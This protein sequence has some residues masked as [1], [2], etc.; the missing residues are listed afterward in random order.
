[1]N[2]ALIKK[3]GYLFFAVIGSLVIS[4]LF[5]SCM[6]QTPPSPELVSP[7]IHIK[8]QPAGV[9]SIN[10]EVSGADMETI[11]K[12]IDV[13][14]DEII[15]EVPA[16]S[17]RTFTLTIENP[18]VTFTGEVT[19]DLTAGEEVD[20]V[21][22]LSLNEST[23][24]VPDADYYS[25]AYPGGRLVQIDDMNGSGWIERDY[26][27]LNLGYSLQEDFVPYDVDFDSRGRIYVANYSSTNGGIIRLGHINDTN[28]TQILSSNQ[29]VALAVDRNNDWIYFIE[30]GALQRCDVN[31]ANRKT[32][33]DASAQN[34]QGLCV[35]NEGMLYMVSNPDG[36]LIQQIDPSG[37]GVPSDT[38][39][40]GDLDYSWDVL[41][42]DN[43]IYVAD[44]SFGSAKI[45]RFTKD[46]TYVDELGYDP[47]N[48]SDQFEGPH[49]FLAVLNRGFIVIDEYEQSSDADDRL[50][51]FSGIS[52]AG[53]TTYQSSTDPFSFFNK[54]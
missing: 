8:G 32:Y 31:G 22:T 36:F 2:E 16:G 5:F 35:D 20:I 12:T 48:H 47:E 38:G 41:F 29:I 25:G 3:T 9:T 42:A 6:Y 24:I 17:D 40:Y 34:A 28:P 33:A 26:S 45:V 50:V 39:N 46:L 4:V 53:W 7:R 51:M 15:L 21:I 18:S 49:R 14:D 11:E 37:T 23:I 10:L 19:E 54:Y 27:N 1:M 44:G 13:G 30:A 43:Y 52:G